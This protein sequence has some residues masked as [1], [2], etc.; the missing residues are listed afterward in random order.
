MTILVRRRFVRQ[1]LARAKEIELARHSRR[2]FEGG[3]QRQFIAK[4]LRETLTGLG[5]EAFVVVVH[6]D[7]DTPGFLYVTLNFQGPAFERSFAFPKQ[8]PVAV[9]PATIAIVAS[10]DVAEQPHVK[11]IRRVRPEFEGRKVALVERADV[12]PGPADAMALQ[13]MDDSEAVPA[14]MPE[15]D[16]KPKIARELLKKSDER[17]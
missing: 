1:L 4:L 12:A 7:P 6:E 15:I 10:A 17:A 5:S 16:R 11:K 3:R 13:K 9:K 14:V 8:M 2:G